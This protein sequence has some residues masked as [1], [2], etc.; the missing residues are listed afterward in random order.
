MVQDL[1]RF[2]R[3]DFIEIVD[4]PGSFPSNEVHS[5]ALFASRLQFLEDNAHLLWAVFLQYM[6]PE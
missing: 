5:R 6:N 4:S 3:L 1:V 2:A